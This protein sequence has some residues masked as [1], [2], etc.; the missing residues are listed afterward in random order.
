MVGAIA[1][2]GPREEE[3]SVA[4]K[5]LH[6]G[7][8][9]IA[10]VDVAVRV[11]GHSVG[12]VELTISRTGA[13]DGEEELAARRRVDANVVVEAGDPHSP[14]RIHLDILRSAHRRPL[15][16]VGRGRVRCR[17]E[18]AECDQETK[19]CCRRSSRGAPLVDSD[20]VHGKASSLLDPALP[21]NISR[22]GMLVPNGNWRSTEQTKFK[23]VGGA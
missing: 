19:D 9:V 17:A 21:L 6:S 3:G 8:R 11:E 20:A 15:L 5:L 12:V 1:G 14:R 16:G 7:R 23:I 10:D 4:G 13:A 18:A 2:N 22:G